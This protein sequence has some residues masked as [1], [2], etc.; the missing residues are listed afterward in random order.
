MYQ[1]FIMNIQKQRS[2]LTYLTLIVLAIITMY[3]G[4]WLT[5]NH[6]NIRVWNWDSFLMIAIGIPFI[7]LQKESGLPEVWDPKVSNRNR[8]WIPLFT[9]ILF[10]IA[11][12]IAVKII[13]HPEPY[14]EMPPFLQPFPYSI[15]L[16]SSGA[17]DVEVTYRLIPITLLMLLIGRFIL[18]GKY[19]AQLL[20]ILAIITGFIEPIDQLVTSPTWFAIYAMITG[21]AMNFIQGWN[22]G[23]FGFLSA[24]FVRLGHYLIWHILLGIYV[25]FFELV[26]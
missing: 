12:L 26:R 13:Q 22:F 20:L 16:Y 24:L 23:R 21:F 10:G 19:N 1:S 11:D 2:L 5:Q 7:L 15:F 14:T 17:F 8:L 9:G 3:Y 4:Q 25:E 18:K 6:N